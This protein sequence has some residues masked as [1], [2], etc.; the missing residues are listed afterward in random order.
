M[1]KIDIKTKIEIGKETF[2]GLLNNDYD[3]EIRTNV[4]KKYNVSLST[5]NKCF[6]EFKDRIIEPKPTEEELEKIAVL[7]KKKQTIVVDKKYSEEFKIQVGKELFDRLYET[8]YA[9]GVREEI[10]Q[11]YNIPLNMANNMLSFYKNRTEEP[12]PTEKQ[13]ED[14][15]K[16]SHAKFSR[17]NFPKDIVNIMLGAT[18]EEL[19]DIIKEYSL[20]R[21]NYKIE[22]RKLR[23]ESE[24]ET[25][26]LLQKRLEKINQELEQVKD[27]LNPYEL[28]LFDTVFNEYLNGKDYYPNY[29]FARYN[30]SKNLFTRWVNLI[31]LNN[32]IPRN[33]LLNNYYKEM[34]IRELDFSI[35]VHDLYKMITEENKNILDFYKMTHMTINKFKSFMNLGLEHHIIPEEE[36][37]TINNFFDLYIVG[38]Y[39][40]A[41]LDE[42]YKIV[43]EYNGINMTKEDIK[44]ICMELVEQDIPVTKN[45]IILTFEEKINNNV[46]KK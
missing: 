14:M 40:L 17:T 41:N 22:Y 33:E 27:T 23:N 19:K 5:V 24:K 31:K 35:L 2:Y 28:E 7:L 26:E 46:Y 11:K 6:S 15:K 21:L 45:S 32:D 30:I 39:S 1:A 10:A 18:D 29:V 20:Y 13:L 25:L 36:I 16:F 43:Y 38:A 9:S 37:N 34:K 4:A 42:A 8:R 3:S 12:K 44:N